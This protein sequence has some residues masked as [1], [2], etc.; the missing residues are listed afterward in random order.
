VAAP[1]AASD[2]TKERREPQ[3]QAAKPQAAKPQA[4]K[5]PPW[6]DLAAASIGSH[7]TRVAPGKLG[8]GGSA[9]FPKNVP[10]GEPGIT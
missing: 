10:S 4:A 7:L 9:P 5:P 6:V 3:P 2:L 8:L 1:I